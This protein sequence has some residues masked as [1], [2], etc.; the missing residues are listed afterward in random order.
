MALDPRIPL[1]VQ[2]VQTQQPNMLGQYAQIMGIRAAQQD[3]QGNEALREAYASGGDLN[4]PEFRRRVMAAN[5]KL[6]SELIK[7]NAETGKL[8]NE[9]VLKR[10]ELSR[11]MLTGVNTPEDYIA[12]HESNHKDPVLGGYLGQR[13]IT[14]EQSRAKIIADLSKPGG[15][16]KLKRESALGATT[17][18]KE[19]MQTERSTKVANIGAGATMRGQDITDRRLRE[20]MAFDQQK[21][22][23]IAGEGEFLQTDDYGNVYRVEGFGPMRG[24]NAPAPAMPPAAANAFVTTQPSVNALAPT[25]P[26][27]VQPGSPTVANAL[28]LEQQQNIPRPR[29]PFSAPVPVID[30]SGNTV[31]M[32]GREAV[33][34]GATP[35][36]PATEA[37]ASAV[38]ALPATI[39]QAKDA[40]NLINRMVGTPDGKSKP[41]KGFEGA[42]GAGMGMRF[43][44]GTSA[45]D[46]QAMHEQI[47]GG[48]FMQAFE[49]LKGGGQITE[50]EGEKATAAITRMSLATSEKEY[51]VA[52]REFQEVIRRG[53]QNAE[54]EL[55]AGPGGGG[56]PADPLG[57]R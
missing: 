36:T 29:Q 3:I 55:R 26:P 19:L 41:H 25:A 8:Q 56:A 38:R 27:V 2:P 14:A 49:T 45:R 37:R 50:K 30:K 16:E 15:L 6:G 52:A 21:R 33:Q 57:I 39:S 54:K 10:I 13:G 11:E 44:P 28:A 34:T 12:W 18:Q 40:L 51:M 7:R 22:K 47:T 17:L 48:A 35:A 31:L 24:P 4:D 23:V 9:A 53:I 43:I 20:Q 1:G 42:V 46:F 32:Q 5:P